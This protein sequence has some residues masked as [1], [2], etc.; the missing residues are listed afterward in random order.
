MPA[1]AQDKAEKK[2]DEEPPPPPEEK[3]LATADGLELKATYY[4]GTKGQESIPVILVHGFNKGKG[5][6][7]DFTQGLAPYLQEKL[8]CFVIV[9]DLRGYGESTKLKKTGQEMEVLDDRKKKAEELK[10]KRRAED[11]KKKFQGQ[12]TEMVTDD[13]RAVKDFLW[14]KNNEKALNLDKLT[15]IGVEEGAAVALSYAAYDAV[16]YEQQE[17]QVGPLKLGKFVKSVV[18][19]SPVTKFKGSTAQ[20]AMKLPE[21]HRDMSVMIVV[22]NKLKDHVLV[23]EQLNN[24]FKKARPSEDELKVSSRTLFYFS[25]IDTALQGCKLLDEPS[26]NMPAKIAHFL[27]LRLVDNQIAKDKWVWRVLKFPHE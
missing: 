12:V 18:L 27:Q 8:G 25:N 6:R 2:A 15:V 13:L 1:W 17:A 21:V 16:G 4:P 24:M 26:L 5:N 11:L 20:Q 3:D 23:A 9:P 10:D 19:I 14:K 7:K 22:G